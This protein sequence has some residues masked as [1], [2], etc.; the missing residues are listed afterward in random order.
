MSDQAHR[1]AVGLHDP[2]GGEELDLLEIGLG[3][4]QPVERV[5]MHQRQRR[6]CNGVVGDD[7]QVLPAFGEKTLSKC[8]RIDVEP[9]PLARRSRLPRGRRRLNCFIAT[10]GLA[11]ISDKP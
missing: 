2:V 3:D 4:E 1:P 5:V 11:S 6:T 7:R 9:R 10:S 8:G